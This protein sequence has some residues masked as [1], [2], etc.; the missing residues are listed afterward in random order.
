MRVLFDGLLPESASR[1]RREP[2]RDLR[3]GSE[4]NWMGKDGTTGDPQKTGST[5]TFRAE[6]RGGRPSKTGT[7]ALTQDAPSRRIAPTR[8]VLVESVI[9]EVIRELE[10]EERTSLDILT[11]TPPAR[12]DVVQ[13]G[14]KSKWRSGCGSCRHH[15][16]A[17]LPSPSPCRL[18]F[19]W[20]APP[21]SSN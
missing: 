4:P 11:P 3:R 18:P 7:F 17:P 10:E 2:P 8:E 16:Q 1:S 12:I 6:T 20:C 14:P 5:G 13:T 21:S 15:L 9:G 19:P